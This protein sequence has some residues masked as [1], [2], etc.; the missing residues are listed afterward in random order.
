MLIPI[1]AIRVEQKPYDPRVKRPD[2]WQIALASLFFFLSLAFG[3]SYELL[4]ELQNYIPN[5]INR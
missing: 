5:F 1:Y 3:Y 4:T 2:A